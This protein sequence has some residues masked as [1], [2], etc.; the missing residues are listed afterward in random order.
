MGCAV[1]SRNAL[2]TAETTQMNTPTLDAAAKMNR[3]DGVGAAIV[4][5]ENACTL[6]RDVEGMMA[7]W[8]LS[9]CSVLR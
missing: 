1:D 8:K 5:V 2:A 6:R 3:S 4:C 9:K 7:C